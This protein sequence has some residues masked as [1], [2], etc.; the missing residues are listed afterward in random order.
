[1]A[2]PR[3]RRD[4][5]RPGPREPIPVRPRDLRRSA[6]GED[7]LNWWRRW[8]QSIS[9]PR[10]GA[11]PSARFDGETL[12]RAR[13][14]PVPEHARQR[15]ATRFSWDVAGLQ[16]SVLDGLRARRTGRRGRLGRRRLVGR[17]L[18]P[19]RRRRSTRR[20]PRCT[21]AT[22]AAPRRSTAVFARVPARELYQRTGIQLLPINTIFELAAHGG[23]A[24]S[25]RSSAPH[26]A[27]HPR[28]LPLLALRQQDVRVHERD[29]DPVLRPDRRSL[30]GRPP[31]TASTSR[32]TLFPEIVAPGT[33]LGSLAPEAA[34]ATGLGRADVVAV[35]THD[36]GSAV[37]AVP[38]LEAGSVFLSIGTW[39]LVGVEVDAA[40]DRRRLLRGQPDERRWSRR[41][42]SAPAQ[43]RRA[44]AARR[45]PPLLGR[46]GQRAHLRRARLA[47][48]GRTAFPGIRRSERGAVPRARRHAG[49]HQRVLP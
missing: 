46:A 13:G 3:R 6:R 1:M 23:R 35:A 14:P 7:G 37:A 39:S 43:R 27:P 36:T 30:G 44:L 22:S 9:A 28:P 5:R 41:D 49:A 38:L 26:A 4:R 15:R 16:R 20:R 47:R 42:L 45:M 2:T 25:W 34:E 29:D 33:R 48:C 31:A 24:R 12:D 32:S 40:G 17:R 19:A 11:S 8:P 18:R 21:T 10:A